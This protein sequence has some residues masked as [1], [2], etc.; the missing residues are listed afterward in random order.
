MGCRLSAFVVLKL[1]LDQV[2]TA[3]AVKRFGSFLVSGLCTGAYSAV[4]HLP[5]SKNV[6]RCLLQAEH[7]KLLL[8]LGKKK[9]V[10]EGCMHS[11]FAD[12]IAMNE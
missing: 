12:R 7:S 2:Y 6:S 9:E 8:I 1:W 3:F 11:A 10:T 5:C 4:Y